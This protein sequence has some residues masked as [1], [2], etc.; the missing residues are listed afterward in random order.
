M[1]GKH[2]HKRPIIPD[3]LSENNP[4]FYSRN[5][6]QGKTPVP[7]SDI[8]RLELQDIWQ[9][10][11]ILCKNKEY[12]TDRAWESVKDQLTAIQPRSGILPVY[13]LIYRIAAVL[14][15]GLL[16]GFLSY[17]IFQQEDVVS[18]VNHFS[19]HV[20]YGSKSSVVLPDGTS[21]WIN[22]GSTIEYT[23][24]FNHEYRDV[25]LDG[26]AFFTVSSNQGKPFR[27]WA[28]SSMIQV[29]GTSFNIKAYGDEGILETTVVEGLVEV[30]PDADAIT[31][32]QSIE[33]RADQLVKIFDEHIPNKSTKDSS[34][35]ESGQNSIKEYSPGINLVTNIKTEAVTSWKDDAWIIESEPL[36]EIA[37]KMERR[38]NVKMILQGEEI[39]NYVYSGVIKDESLEQM[40]RAISA[41]SPVKFRLEEQTVYIF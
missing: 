11:G 33:L 15:I 2:I 18:E 14:I 21:I 41:T 26:E 35:F 34:A 20:P 40:M 29:V 36:K 17:M 22:A 32:K 23:R 19:Y 13:R 31:R 8:E 5:E 4:E 27:V 6:S 16:S 25:R 10:T 12:N 9:A 39:E 38:F 24:D 37:I 7:F 1:P 28:K 3:F 30:Y